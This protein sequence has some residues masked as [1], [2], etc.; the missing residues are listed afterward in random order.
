M[1]PEFKAVALAENWGSIPITTR[2]LTTI[3]ISV[4]GDLTSNSSHF[5]EHQECKQS[6]HSHKI[7][8]NKKLWIESDMAVNAPNR[9]HPGGRGRQLS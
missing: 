3:L 4:P 7:K 5:N 9:Q 6:I 8:I 2:R 1:A